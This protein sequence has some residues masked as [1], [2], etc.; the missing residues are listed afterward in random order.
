MRKQKTKDF[1]GVGQVGNW[2]ANE[3]HQKNYLMP[4]TK[5]GRYLVNRGRTGGSCSVNYL[6]T[7]DG[8]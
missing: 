5:R 4:Q 6:E 1:N 8:K 7:A 3:T 2:F